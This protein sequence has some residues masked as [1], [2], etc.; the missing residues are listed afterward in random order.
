MTV[1]LLKIFSGW[2]PMLRVRSANI[3][4]TI[5]VDRPIFDDRISNFIALYPLAPSPPQSIEG[6]FNPDWG[7]PLFGNFRQKILL[8]ILHLFRN[9]FGGKYFASKPIFLG[10]KTRFLAGRSHQFKDLASKPIFGAR[11]PVYRWFV[12]AI[13]ST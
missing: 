12:A 8:E 9:R 11:N 2:R 13:Q 5:R 6:L 1:N 3:S 4:S 10:K 7:S